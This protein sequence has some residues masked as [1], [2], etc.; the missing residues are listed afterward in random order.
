VNQDKDSF[1]QI[2]RN[3]P[4][5]SIDLIL[6][7]ER[8]EILLGYRR[9]RPA[10]NCWFVPGGRIRKGESIQQALKRIARHELGILPDEGRLLGAFDHFYDDNFFGLPDVATHYVAL[11]Y[12]IDVKSEIGIAG[13]DQHTELKWWNMENLLSSPAV[14]DN[15]KLYFTTSSENG[16]R[17][18]TVL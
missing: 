6:R 2:I 13:D 11:A 8:N 4:L 3:A 5:V 12:L 10:Q 7:N 1:L 14:H 18:P 15:T 17:A 16:F 9:N